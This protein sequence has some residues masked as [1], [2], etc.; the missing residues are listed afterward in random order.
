MT[1]DE[2]LPA[3]NT[4]ATAPQLI[5]WGILIV[6][7]VGLIGG[8]IY[9]KTH[10][11]EPKLGEGVGADPT[12]IK[13]GSNAPKPEDLF[14]WG[15][16][17]DFSLVDQSGKRIEA[18][19][20]RGE[21]W[22]ANFIFTRCAGTCPQM[23][24]AM[25]DLNTELADV[26]QV[27]LVS[28]TMD[29]EFDTP[30]VLSKYAFKSEAVSPRWLFLTGDKDQI[31]KLTREQFQLTTQPNADNVEEPIIHSSLFVLVDADGKIRGRFPGL[32]QDGPDLASMKLLA[33]SV[34]KLRTQTKQPREPKAP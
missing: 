15:E 9:K 8:A 17:K 31:Y 2:Q 14:V 18:K 10:P 11:P 21:A 29:P 5:A 24:R 13:P 4:R 16:I 6:V 23:V 1:D 33:K 3:S 22:V 20:L 12:V 34:R 25:K 30:E 19:D 27:K 7:V 32:T 26:P 28:F